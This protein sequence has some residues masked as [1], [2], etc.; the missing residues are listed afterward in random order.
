M[1]TVTATVDLYLSDSGQSIVDGL[2]DDWLRCMP[3]RTVT[4]CRYSL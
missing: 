2:V 3:H 4:V 1:K